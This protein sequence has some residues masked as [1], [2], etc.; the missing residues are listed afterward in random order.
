MQ[1]IGRL[2]DESA[3]RMRRG[4]VSQRVVLPGVRHLARQGEV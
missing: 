3:L 4:G 1:R 2:A